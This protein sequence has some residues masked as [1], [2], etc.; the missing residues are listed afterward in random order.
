MEARPH[1]SQGTQGVQSDTT[2]D[3]NFSKLHFEQ[4][5]EPNTAPEITTNDAL[6][7]TQ[8]NALLNV[9]DN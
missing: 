5:T 6:N 1:D 2:E 4:N 8:M 9:R 3:N 7:S